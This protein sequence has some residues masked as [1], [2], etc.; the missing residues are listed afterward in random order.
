MLL[1]LERILF[2]FL[3]I[4]TSLNYKKHVAL[5]LLRINNYIYYLR[6]K[7]KKG[8]RKLNEKNSNNFINGILRFYTS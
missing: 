6:K 8:G 7:L 2:F 1:F 3:F 4:H 5:N